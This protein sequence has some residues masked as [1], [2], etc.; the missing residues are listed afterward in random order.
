MKATVNQLWDTCREIICFDDSE[1][2]RPTSISDLKKCE[3]VIVGAK[4]CKGGP[5][6]VMIDDSI[7]LVMPVKLQHP[8]GGGSMLALEIN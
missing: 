4:I 8:S 7:Y 6:E 3:N 1:F 2:E 5:T